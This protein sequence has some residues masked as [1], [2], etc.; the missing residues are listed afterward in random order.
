MVQSLPDNLAG[1]RDRALLL[2]GFA[3]VGR[4]KLAALD[5]EEVLIKDD[6]LVVRLRRLETDP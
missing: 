4:S 1:C 6:G 5:S 3:G 2:L